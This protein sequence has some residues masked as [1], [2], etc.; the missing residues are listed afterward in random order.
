MANSRYPWRI[1]WVLLVAAVCGVF[2][3]LPYVL[4]LVQ[5]VAPNAAG[6]QMSPAA[7]VTVQVLHLSL[8]FG[9]A[10]GFGLLLA[11]SV[12]LRF[13]LLSRW[14]EGEAT[15]LP[16][17][18]LRAGIVAGVAIGAGTVCA[19]YGFVLPRIP[20]WPSEAAMP[21]STRVLICFYGAINEEVLMRL[22]VL[23]LLLW[24]VQ[25][26][27]RGDGEV[28]G[29]RFLV[30]NVA[31]ALIYGAAYLPA[32]RM[33]VPLTGLLIASIVGVKAIAGVV[34]GELFRRRGL[35]VVMLAHF[36]SDLV[37][38]VLGPLFAR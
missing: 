18:S 35:E 11:R 12:G 31:A 15:S 27:T 22:F 2:A 33:L 1:F 10:I 9:L 30:A 20:Q 7:F 36:I 26:I 29:A 19:L 14:L 21:L 34:F 8:I 24:A 13:P 25:K 17:G 4:V 28:R 23:G 37:I 16:A 32:A 3:L 5:R 38:H 6:V